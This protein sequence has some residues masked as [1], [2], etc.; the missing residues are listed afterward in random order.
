M[1]SFARISGMLHADAVALPRLAE[2]Y[3]TPLYVYS[4]TGI[5]RRFQRLQQA[6]RPLGARIDYSVK[7]CSNL[8]VLR[9][10][11]ELGAGWDVVSA[12]EIE[13]C[14]RA[15]GD[16]T[17]I[18]F[19]GAGK[20]TGEL[21]FALSAGVGRFHVES[22]DELEELAELA[23]RSRQT[24]QVSLRLNPG[25]EAP[26]HSYL[27]TARVGD[28]FGVDG[29]TL[30][31]LLVSGAK[32]RSLHVDGLHLHLGSQILSVEPFV[33]AAHL[34]RELVDWAATQGLTIQELN[35]GG[36]FGAT[37]E[38]EELDVTKVAEHW[39]EILQG[40]GLSLAVEPGRALVGPEA[41]LLTRV[42]RVKRAGSRTVVITDAGMN[43]F[44]RPALYGAE[45][46]VSVV[47][48]AEQAVESC[49]DF[50]GPVC[51]SGDFLGRDRNSVVPRKGELL[52]LQD[53]GAY[54]FSMASNYNSRPRPAEVLV[55]GS[56]VRCIRRRETIDDLMSLEQEE[57]L[58]PDELR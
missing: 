37:A 53:A 30:R 21:E 49:V 3:G 6:F 23:E 20:S 5:R 14:L 25:L 27:S 58:P 22:R 29:Q 28:K 38:G 48:T 2:K 34:C 41:V 42:L 40:R 18:S 47:T 12:G 46:T 17:R 45:H 10:L 11:G 32:L 7:A 31:E 55:H 15:G 16:A 19:A 43:D 9:L 54:G 8:A 51:E 26:T 33:A 56:E 36:G 1:N 4:E 24:A 13:R 50:V 39:H 52:A 57:A 44:L 35:L